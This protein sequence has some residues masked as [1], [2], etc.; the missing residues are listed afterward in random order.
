MAK[1]WYRRTSKKQFLLGVA[2]G[3]LLIGIY[4]MQQKGSEPTA[5]LQ[6]TTHAVPAALFVDGQY[7]GHTPYIAKHMRPGIKQIEITPDDTTLR[8]F[9][10]ELNIRQGTLSVIDWQ[11]TSSQLESSGVVLTLSP[12]DGTNEAQIVLKTNP[13]FAVPTLDGERI[14]ARAVVS[15]GTHTLAA[16]APGYESVEHQITA[17][18]GMQLEIVL[19]LA[20]LPLPVEVQEKE[21]SETNIEK[22]LE[23]QEETQSQESAESAKTASS[24]TPLAAEL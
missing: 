5:G 8:S 22:S 1:Q 4:A 24:S 15:P 16:R 9:S 6:V 21:Q 19:Q 17:V 23:N 3:V 20:K 14:E 11:L 18:A 2:A 13:P 7:I 12:I 10:T